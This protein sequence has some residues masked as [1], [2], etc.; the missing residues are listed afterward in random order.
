MLQGMDHPS[1]N[2]RL[3]ELELLSVEKRRLQGDLIAAFQ[4]LKG[5]CRKE[6]DRLLSTVY[7][8]VRP[9]SVTNG[10]KGP[11]D[12][13]PGKRERGKRGKGRQMGL[14]TEQ[15][16]R[17]EEESSFTKKILECKITHCNTV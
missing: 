13:H 11:T 6:R 4:Y 17:S 7:G 3:R 2:D 9:S 1:Y 14:E 16:K 12:P 10:V 15:Q 8:L 5:S